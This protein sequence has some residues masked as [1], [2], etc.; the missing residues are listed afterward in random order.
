MSTSSRSLRAELYINKDHIRD[1]FSHTRS[2]I[3]IVQD[4]VCQSVFT[5]MV[6]DYTH[7]NWKYFNGNAEDLTLK[8]DRNRVKASRVSKTWHKHFRALEMSVSR[9]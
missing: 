4:L 1:K 7:T 9:T 8:V 2:M 6:P 5:G 3:H